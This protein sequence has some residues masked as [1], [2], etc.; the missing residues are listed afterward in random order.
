MKKIVGAV[1]CVVAL[2]GCGGPL[3]GD[4]TEVGASQAALLTEK[5]GVAQP[6]QVL[7]QVNQNLIKNPQEAVLRA[8]AFQTLDHVTDP[9][10]ANPCH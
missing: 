7:P 10:H 6:G 3:E 5:T 1:L 9:L 4:G 2:V 8:A